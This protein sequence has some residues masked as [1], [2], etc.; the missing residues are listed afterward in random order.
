L[1]YLFLLILFFNTMVTYRLGASAERRLSAPKSY[2]FPFILYLLITL[3]KSVIS[4][5]KYD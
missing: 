5:A 4:E 3:S 2:E 1:W